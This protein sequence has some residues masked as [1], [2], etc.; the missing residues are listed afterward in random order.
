V[1]YP[2]CDQ[3]KN[4]GE[5]EVCEMCDEGDY[6]DPIEDASNKVIPILEAA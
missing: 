5:A 1:N 3:C 4:F 6:F 2:F